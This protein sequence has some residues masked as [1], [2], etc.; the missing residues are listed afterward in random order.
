MLESIPADVRA[1]S[2]VLV[3]T[4]EWFIG[5]PKAPLAMYWWGAFTEWCTATDAGIFND[6]A[7]RGPL[8]VFRSRTTSFR[9]MLQPSTGEFRDCRNRRAS[10]RGFLMRHQAVAHDLLAALA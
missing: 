6:Y 5:S 10:W 1:C 3:E 7:Q 4:D 2:H 9:W 8:I